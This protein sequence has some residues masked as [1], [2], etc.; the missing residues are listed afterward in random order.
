[1]NNQNQE[2]RMPSSAVWQYVGARYVPIFADP[3]EWQPNTAYEPLT[4]VTYNRNSYTSRKP[5]PAGV[6]PENSDYWANTGNFNA[7]LDDL[8]SKIEGWDEKIDQA[9]ESVAAAVTTANNAKATADQALTSAGEAQNTAN[10][11]RE[12]ADRAETAATNALNT[13]QQLETQVNENT[14]NI[15]TN[16]AGIAENKTAIAANKTAIDSLKETIENVD[17]PKLK[18]QIAENAANITQL[19]TEST[20]HGA[21]IEK[22]ASDITALQETDTTQATTIS[23]LT[24]RVGNLETSQ[25]AQDGKITA[26]ETGLAETKTYL[27]GVSENV[28][29]ISEQIETIKEQSDAATAE[30]N[31]LTGV[32]G[33]ENTG[34]IHDFQELK[35]AVESGE[36][37]EALAGRVGLLETQVGNPAAE[38]TPATGIELKLEQLETANSTTQTQV[39]ALRA[40]VG[41]TAEGEE[42]A[43]GIE[44]EIADLKQKVGEDSGN[45]S[46]RITAIEATVGDSTSG[47]VKDV[48]SNMGDIAALQADVSEINA[49]QSA[50]DT[51]ISGNTTAISNM[52]DRVTAA[53][54]AADAAQET[55]D[56]AKTSAEAAQATADTAQAAAEAAQTTAT[57]AETAANDAKNGLNDK[58]SI[59]GGTMTGVIR[60]G[61]PHTSQLPMKPVYQDV[62]PSDS[63]TPKAVLHMGADQRTITFGTAERQIVSSESN[64]VTLTGIKSPTQNYDAANKKYVDSKIP[65]PTYPIVYVNNE[66]LPHSNNKIVIGELLNPQP[67]LTLS[68]IDYSN[69]VF[70]NLH[71]ELT[72]DTSFYSCRFINCTI[73]ESKTARNL[74]A[75]L[76]STFC[77][78]CL[79]EL[80]VLLSEIN[81]N[82]EAFF[83]NCF[84][85]DEITSI[86]N[87][88]ILCV[89]VGCKAPNSSRPQDSQISPS[90]YNNTE[91]WMNG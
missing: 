19:Q 3:I 28:T 14:D 85:T 15:T 29:N 2:I 61:A 35:N 48:D 46:E 71:I 20:A 12:V 38:G 77:S 58:L 91:E 79:F 34:L 42:P 23:G 64:A 90:S 37:V 26:L 60:G 18:E 54:T 13:V 21:A 44:K 70:C 31:R 69:I 57:A 40:Q 50:Q 51:A 65:V 78:N 1:M 41:K 73:T 53:R 66:S 45:L 25:T 16:T 80:D 59:S 86:S 39:D 36:S 89:F 17:F 63:N 55:A 8:T 4:I 22:N 68:G 72:Q 84:F 27:Q 30:V 75:T 49:Q 76:L 56:T 43:T 10:S 82:T 87:N 74:T 7:Q 9:E 11:V 6:S 52:S 83:Y 47:L 62:Y 24:E 88:P 33:D 5:V 67:K 81:A 32:V